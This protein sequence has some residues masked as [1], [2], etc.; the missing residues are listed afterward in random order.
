MKILSWEDYPR[1]VKESTK[2]PDFK[3]KAGLFYNMVEY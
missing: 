1:E 3:N 2:E